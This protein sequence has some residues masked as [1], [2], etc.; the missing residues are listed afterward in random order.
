MTK[1]TR[2]LASCAVLGALSA[3]ALAQDTTADTVVASVNGTEITLGHM[4]ALREGLPQQYQALPDDV[5]FKGILDQLI[6]QT[7]LEQSVGDL[8][9]RDQLA[10]ENDRRGYISG[11]ALQAVVASA[12]TDEALQAAY[13][14]KFK[15]L[16]PS[17][18]YNAAHILVDSEEKAN[19]LKTQLD[20]GADFAELAR[21]NSSDTGSGANGGDLGWFGP[22]MMVKPFEDAV[23]AAEIG[24]VTAP[25]K[26]DFGFH[27][28]LVKETRV[29]AAPTLDETRDEL[30]AEIERA[31]VDAHIKTLTDAAEVTRPGEGLDPT[32]LRDATLLDK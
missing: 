15:A 14:A 24:K 32:L 20:G 10:L 16:E 22:G 31:A 19:E 9:K 5:L 17:T 4:I 28:I 29:A 3:P 13:D 12:V 6:Q 18:E 8:A 21:E 1:M 27:L 11:V 2:F 7:A 23:I 26:S 30:A 25:V